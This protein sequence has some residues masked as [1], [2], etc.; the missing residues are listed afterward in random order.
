[1]QVAKTALTAFGKKGLLTVFVQV[2]N[3]L[4]GIQVGNHRSDRNTKFNIGCASAVAV[5]AAAVFTV[6]RL[7]FTCVAIV[8]Q[9]IQISVC[10]CV[11][12]A[13]AAAVSA[14]RA[15][16]WN[17]FFASE[18]S[19]AVSALTRKNFNFRFI[20]KFHFLFPV[21]KDLLGMELM[22]AVEK[23]SAPF[24]A[25]NGALLCLIRGLIKQPEQR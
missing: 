20:Y 3:R 1:M 25:R 18:G 19:N 17:K 7:E 8:D 21:R 5:T 11:N 15:A 14:V 10:N 24:P 22:I 13:A 4:T 6:L 12:R 9:S 23:I 2:G 16:F